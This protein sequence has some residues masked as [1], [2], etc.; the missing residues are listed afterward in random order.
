MTSSLSFA[1][2]LES[3]ATCNEAD[4]LPLALVYGDSTI[5]CE[6]NP[7]TDSDRFTFDGTIGDLARISV[8]TT[9]A[10]WNPTLELRDDTNTLID[11]A[12]CN[13][14]SFS[15]CSFSLDVV[16][17]KTGTYLIILADSGANQSGS[18][19]L[20]LHRIVPAPFMAQ[21]DYDAHEADSIGPATDI[22]FYDFVATAGTSLR[23]NVV[24][25]TANWNPRVEV[26]DPTGTLVLN[27]IVDGAGCN[28]PSFSTC[29][30]SV[31]LVPASSGTY[32]VLIYD[33]DTNLGGG[34]EIGLWCVYGPC[35]GAPTPDPDGPVLN[36]VTA[37]TDSIDPKVDG[38]FFTFNATADTSLR[39]NVVTTTANW[40]PRVEVRDPTG[41]A[42]L[43]GIVDGAGCNPPSFSTCSFSVDLDSGFVG[44]LF[45]IDL[46][47]RHES[48]WELPHEPMVHSG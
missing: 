39:L 32:S 1:Q 27:G 16:L 41:A 22:D 43:N 4:P 47:F 31:D 28:P 9:S 26:R 42:V 29:S 13:P 12:F 34:Y 44:Y 20:Q 6:I 33:A 18:Y 19:L 11:T 7:P 36:F 35:D 40:N 5:G 46:R 25:T 8:L 21:L 30:F 23:L 48:N 45:S 38:D 17:P 14:P 37:T 2:Q 24:T 3:T 10:N 15:T